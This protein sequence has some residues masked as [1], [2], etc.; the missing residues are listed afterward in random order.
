MDHGEQV[1]VQLA[2]KATA[3]VVGDIAFEDI[4]LALAS[5]D[6]V[7]VAGL[8][9]GGAGGGV[10]TVGE[11]IGGDFLEAVDD[12]SQVERQLACEEDDAVQMVGHELEVEQPDAVVH[13]C[14]APPGA[15]RLTSQVAVD[16]ARRV[17][18][19]LDA[20]E[21]L[22]AGGRLDGDHVDAAAVVVVSVA[23]AVH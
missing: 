19:A 10:W 15:F 5:E 6:A 11:G 12:A 18:G 13:L 3:R 1:A 16:K 20:P 17:V 21:G 9:E 7:V 14:A 8:P 2:E 22:A 23:A 4:E